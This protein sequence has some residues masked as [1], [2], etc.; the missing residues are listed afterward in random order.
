MHDNTLAAALM[1]RGCDVTL[2]PLY[3]PI[4]T[5]EQSVSIDRVFFGGINAYLQQKWS[6]FRYLPK[7]M[8]GWLNSPWLIRKVAGGAVSVDAEVLG[9][10]TLSALKGDHGNQAKEVARMLAWLKREAKP[11]LVN[12]TNLLIGG[13]APVIKEELG[14]PVLVTL[15]GDD[16]FLEHLVEPYRSEVLAEM[17]R[18]ARQVDGFVVNSEFYADAMAELLEEPREKFHLI[19]LG[20][21]LSDFEALG[22]DREEGEGEQVIG[23][24]A[25]ICPEKGFHVLVDA[26]IRL[27]EWPDTRGY[28]LR[29]GGW[30]GADDQEY[31][32]AQEEKLRA[33]GL[34]DSFEYCGVLDREEKLA[35]YEGIDVFSVP[36]IY[37]EPKGLYVLE[38]LA[39]GVPVVQPA[40]GIFPEM[41]EQTGGGELVT[42]GSAAELA[43]KLGMLLHDGARRR[44]LGAAG[45]DGVFERFSADDMARATLD[46]YALILERDR[47]YA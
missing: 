39:S 1:R 4:R 32:E 31:F 29:A 15:Q 22:R 25:R 21:K 28:T 8:D 3:T 7:W 35:F 5:D 12:L 17:K 42:P 26:F 24:L 45:R 36:A 43:E 38:A 13:F 47:R 30:L 6:I 9:E 23:Y 20:L 2:V 14:V 34:I 16:I 10:L 40:H 41:I 19:P 46:L 18:L 27:R 44:S 33:A 37:R 11:D